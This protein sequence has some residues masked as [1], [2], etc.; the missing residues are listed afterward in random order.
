MAR[1]QPAAYSAA[2]RAK[3]LELRPSSRQQSH[4]FQ[5]YDANSDTVEL[6]AFLATATDIKKLLGG[7]AVNDAWDS[8]RFTA[9]ADDAAPTTQRAASARPS[10]RR[11]RLSAEEQQR[12]QAEAARKLSFT[13][14]R[15]ES[16]RLA[17][18]RD[19]ARAKQRGS[20]VFPIAATEALCA[21]LVKRQCQC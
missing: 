8:L 20:R 5:A 21:R 10:T 6:E 17:C 12:A 11:P 16:S 14:S 7:T 1:I 18:E 15:E 2:K 19:V 3:Q 13:K 4:R 9:V